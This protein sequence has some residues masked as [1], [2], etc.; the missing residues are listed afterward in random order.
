VRVELENL[1]VARAR[2][3]RLLG[4]RLCLDFANTVDPR[5]GPE[6]REYLND[7]ADLIAWS[8]IT[9][10]TSHQLAVKL[11]SASQEHGREAAGILDRAIRLRE[12][13]YHLFSGRAA[14]KDD[15]ATLNSELSQ[16]MAGARVL[17]AQPGF[18]WTWPEEETEAVDPARLLWP[19]ARSAAELLTSAERQLVRECLGDNCGWLFLDTSKNHRRTWCSMQGCGNRAKARRHYARRTS[20]G[21]ASSEGAR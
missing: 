2:L 17:P 13:L 15:L 12:A 11:T 7:Y 20:P 18:A 8:R 19:V 9:G 14:D 21:Q 1:E 5:Y 3:P 10:A 4:G 16:A 6:R